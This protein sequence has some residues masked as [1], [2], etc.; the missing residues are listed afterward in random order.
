M[1]RQFRDAH[2]NTTCAAD[3]V[4]GIWNINFLNAWNLSVSPYSQSLCHLP[5]TRSSSTWN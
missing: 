5:T 1:D 3:G 4:I 2:W